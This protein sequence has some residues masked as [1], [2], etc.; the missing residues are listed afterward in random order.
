M[1]G[2][3]SRR[4][5]MFLLLLSTTAPLGVFAAQVPSGPTFEVVSIKRSAP[6]Q[7][8]GSIGIQPGNRF[9]MV[10]MEI[11][12]LIGSA[13]PTD[14]PEYIGAPSW[15][16]SERYDVTAKA[17]EGASRAEME[18]MFRALLA[19]RFNFKGHYETREQPIFELVLAHTDGRLGPEIKKLD[20]DCAA[21]RAASARGEAVPALPP[22]PNGRLP[23]GMSAS[24]GRILSGGM[25]LAS[26]AR[27]IQGGT[28][29]VI[30]DKTGLVGDYE[31]VLTY[32]SNPQA[33]SDRPSLFTALQEQ[34]GLKLESSR[35]P[36]RVFVIDNIER[37]SED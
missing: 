17:P 13:Y 15:V 25:T 31:F 11:R 3:M 35:G 21:R 20:I 28:G 6:N 30:V 2:I 7:D 29:R 8:I 23:C 26:F 19:N 33:D 18:P 27:S 32:T 14:T 34:L 5:Q 36:V 24:P 1:R 4:R 37:P 22:R 10:N 16:T 9:V 12:A